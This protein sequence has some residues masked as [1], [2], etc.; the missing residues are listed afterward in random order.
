VFIS[1]AGGLI[2]FI[3]KRISFIARRKETYK[4][5]ILIVE[6][7]EIVAQLIMEIL[8][9]QGLETEVTRDGIEGLERIKQNEYDLI[10][11][12]LQMPRM[13]GDQLYLEVQKL[14][15]DLAK[16]II[17]ISGEITDFIMSTG[18]RFLAKPFSHQQLIEI[19][20]DLLKTMEKPDP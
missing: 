16:R 10:I 13:K 20:E 2:Y 17:F 8:E 4:K 14:N 9:G 1:G 11:S 19:V 12:N 18:N 15:Q 5:R 6:D 3:V 7:D